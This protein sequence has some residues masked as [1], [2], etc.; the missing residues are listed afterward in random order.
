M[1]K[2]KVQF[3][4]GLSLGEFME[5]YGTEE[6]CR[7]E[8]A[9]M[10]WLEGFICPECGSKSYCVLKS[11]K[12]YQCNNC[13]KQT[14]VTAGTIFHSTK[15]PLIK[16][17]LGMYLLTQSKKGVSSIEL[18]RHMGVS[19]NTGWAIKH[20]LMQ[21][22]LERDNGKK[23]KGRIEVDDA[24]IGGERRNGKRGRGSEN[25]TPFV[26]AIETTKEGHPGKIKLQVLPGFR[27]KEIAHWAKAHLE[28][29]SHVVTDGLRCFT[30]VKDAG[31]EHEAIVVGKKRKSIDLASFLW[32]NTILGNLKTAI[33]GTYHSISSRHLPR[34]LAEFQY[35]FN[36]RFDLKVMIKRLLYSS[37]RTAPIQGRLLTVAENAW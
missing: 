36:R 28:A 23:L 32:V 35:R 37:V 14:S 6:Q 5:L 9:R 2:S 30:A 34:Y 20:K 13:H 15:A 31:C 33:T 21:V 16:W 26:A 25:K 11:R 22:M 4:R 7:E 17:F 27:K 24:Y 18:A 19:Q 12:I 3:Q 29:G 1:A 10:R 8:V